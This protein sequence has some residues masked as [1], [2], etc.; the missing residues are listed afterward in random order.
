MHFEFDTEQC[1][2]DIY[3]EL[4]FPFEKMNSHMCFR[5]VANNNRLA[6]ID[7]NTVL[8]CLEDVEHIAPRLDKSPHHLNSQ[9]ELPL[10]K[11]YFQELM[12]LKAYW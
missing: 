2:Y 6:L 3:Y 11:E 7:C 8:R 4:L 10:L 9:E 12:E 1:H 5:I